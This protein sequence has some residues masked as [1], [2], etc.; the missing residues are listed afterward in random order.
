MRKRSLA[1]PIETHGQPPR[2]TMKWDPYLF[3][4]TKINSGWTKIEELKVKPYRFTKNQTKTKPR[5]EILFI[6]LEWGKPFQ[7]KH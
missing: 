7:I 2:K 4:Y 5:K 6:F 3:I 1:T